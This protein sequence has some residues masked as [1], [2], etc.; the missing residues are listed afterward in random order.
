GLGF[1][2]DYGVGWWQRRA[3]AAED[4]AALELRNAAFGGLYVELTRVAYEPDGNSYRA[5]MFMQNSHD[6]PLYILMSPV[7]V[8]VQTGLTW[9]EVRASAPPGAGTGVVK[10]E[11]GKDY[12]VV[13][14]ADVKDWAELMPGYMHVRIDSRMLISRSPEPKDDI[15]ER[16]NFFYVYLK[17]QGA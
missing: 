1:L 16:N 7:Q 13:F 9:Q 12:S 5:T 8:F 2:A 11:G 10:L 4:A 3:L 15:V 6:Q 14:Q 17:P